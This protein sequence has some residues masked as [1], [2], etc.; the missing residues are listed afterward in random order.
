MEGCLLHVG[1]AGPGFT[2]L[3]VPVVEPIGRWQGRILLGSQ[4]AVMLRFFV[5]EG[6]N[7][8]AESVQRA[9][10]AW[11]P[12]SPTSE[13]A[14]IWRGKDWVA[15]LKPHTR[16]STT[17]LLLVVMLALLA[18]PAHAQRGGFGMA[19]RGGAPPSHGGAARGRGHHGRHGFNGSGFGDYYPFYDPYDDTDGGGEPPP[20]PIVMQAAAPAS[21]APAQA[22]A[23]ESL[24]MELRGDHWVRLTSYGPQ[25]LGS[26]PARLPS[27]SQSTPG[28]P[29]S[30][31]G[32]S[33]LVGRSA[34]G[35]ASPEE[36]EPPAKLP[37]AVLVF[38]DGHQE[39]AAKYT[40]VGSTIFIKADYWS[41]GSW[42][43]QVPI[44]QLDIP[45]TLEANQA[46]GAKFSLP[47]RPG[48][49]MMRP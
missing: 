43:R 13:S 2:G 31:V 1:Q 30:H 22:K 15:H 20:A 6:I 47:S 26:Q 12:F 37:P 46:R 17:A 49:V 35:Q 19:G 4:T 7:S 14:G 41:S 8:L 42:T 16:K 34:S 5:T 33:R 28:Q 45:A 32:P 40:I 10:V 3:T 25:E 21:P 9:A 23:S 36:T 38:R 29:D 48:E 44:A 18:V 24:V 39:E 27:V 11:S